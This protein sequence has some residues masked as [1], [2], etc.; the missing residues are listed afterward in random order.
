MSAP[1]EFATTVTTGSGDYLFPDVPP[2]VYNIEATHQ[3]FKAAESKN[4]ELLVQQALRQDF[5]MAV[6]AGHANRHG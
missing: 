6:G 4:V 2:G 3:G 5:T 1:A